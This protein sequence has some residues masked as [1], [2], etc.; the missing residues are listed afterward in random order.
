MTDSRERKTKQI[1]RLSN[2]FVS[3]TMLTEATR[4]MRALPT[5]GE[6]QEEGMGGWRRERN[7]EQRQSQ[8]KASDIGVWPKRRRKL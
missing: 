8:K 4:T 2:V 5:S 1:T 3:G 6:L 7:K